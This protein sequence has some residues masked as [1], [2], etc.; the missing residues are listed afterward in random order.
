MYKQ[1]YP[2]LAVC[3][4]VLRM[5]KHVC[6]LHRIN[7]RVVAEFTN[8]FIATTILV[9]IENWISPSKTKHK[10]LYLKHQFVPRSKHFLSRV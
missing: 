2:I 6:S 10:Q 3:P 8:L 9:G 7:Y 4:V 1:L 5:S